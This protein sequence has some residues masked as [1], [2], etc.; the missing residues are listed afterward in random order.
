ML[1]LSKPYRLA[2]QGYLAVG[3]DPLSF[4]FRQHFEQSFPKDIF[5][6]QPGERLEVGIHLQETVIDRLAGCVT[7]NLV[8]GE[9]AQQF[10]EQLAVLLL[11]VEH[12]GFYP[13]SFPLFRLL[14]NQLFQ[15]SEAGAEPGILG[16]QIG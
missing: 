6:T 10:L 4:A 9:T 13:L 11:T 2:R 5:G 7:D 3:F 14:R 8:Q 1:K 16:G 12:G 15:G